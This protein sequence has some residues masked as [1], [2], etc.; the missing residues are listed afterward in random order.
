MRKCNEP[1]FTASIDLNGNTTSTVHADY[2]VI[3]KAARIRGCHQRPSGPP[4]NPVS[5]I[6]AELQAVATWSGEHRNSPRR[7][8]IGKRTIMQMPQSHYTLR[9]LCP[10]SA[11]LRLK[12]LAMPDLDQIKQEEQKTGDGSGRFREQNGPMARSARYL[13]YH[14][15]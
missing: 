6:I 2:T 15:A 7:R 8:G 4:F 14:S 5:E 11:K 10:V 13:K 12:E 3:E 1:W 9:H